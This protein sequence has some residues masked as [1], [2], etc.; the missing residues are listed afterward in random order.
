VGCGSRLPVKRTPE[1]SA[2]RYRVPFDPN[3]DPNMH[4]AK[5]LTLMEF[6]VVKAERSAPIQG[7]VLQLPPPFVGPPNPGILFDMDAMM[8]GGI[9]PLQEASGEMWEN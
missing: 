1:P 7:K 3:F 4:R 8:I 9:R 2:I 6:D 5:P